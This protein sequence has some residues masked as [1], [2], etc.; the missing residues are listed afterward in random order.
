M[1]SVSR[2]LERRIIR[3][4]CEVANDKRKQQ[5]RN[6]SKG[7]NNLTFDKNI[8]LFR[9]EWYKHHYD[10]KRVV[11]EKG[12]ITTTIKRKSIKKGDSHQNNKKLLSKLKLSK[13]KQ[14]EISI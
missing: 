5:K 4:E 3:R 11:D 6:A 2:T 8:D 10:T 13:S 14:G 12:N 7:E 9:K 1:S